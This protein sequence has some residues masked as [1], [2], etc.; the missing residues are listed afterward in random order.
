MTNIGASQKRPEGGK[1]NQYE[2]ALK[3]TSSRQTTVFGFQ[4]GPVNIPSPTNI[5]WRFMMAKVDGLIVALG[6]NDVLRGLP[7]EEASDCGDLEGEA[8][9]A[10]TKPYY[11]PRRLSSFAP[12]TNA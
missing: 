7:P 4:C 9:I 12:R 11:A 8:I 2:E 6:G 5:R 1:E 3:A 10:E